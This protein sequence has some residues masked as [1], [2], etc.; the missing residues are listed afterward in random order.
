MIVLSCE[1]GSEQW[2]EAR[3]GIPTASQFKRILTLKGK[4]SFSADGYSA[5]LLAEWALGEAIS[6]FAGNEWTERGKVLES[7]ALAYYSFQRDLDVQTVGF[8]YRDGDRMSGCSPDGL[9]GADGLLELKCP[10]AGKHLLWLARDQVPPEHMMQVQGQLWVS[11]RAWLD[12]MS[13]YPQLPPLIV[14]VTPDPKIQDALDV[15]I[16]TFIAELLSG[17]ERLV[18]LG[19]QPGGAF[20]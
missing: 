20:A 19:I 11:G 14:R 12:W 8:L 15:E 10:S 4:S 9:V 17:R 1:Q 3:L 16:P 2:S 18:T 6:D 13:F 5:E 7:E